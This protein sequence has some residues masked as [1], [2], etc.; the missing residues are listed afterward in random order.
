MEVANTNGQWGIV[1]DEAIDG[2]TPIDI[3]AL[4]YC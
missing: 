3:V 2:D 4:L 1:K